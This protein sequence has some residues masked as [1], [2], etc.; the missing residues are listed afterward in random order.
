MKNARPTPTLD[1]ILGPNE[2][3]T[4]RGGGHKTKTLTAIEIRASWPRSILYF[5]VM[6]RSSHDD[7]HP[8]I[9]VAVAVHCAPSVPSEFFMDCSWVEARVEEQGRL[10][11]D[12]KK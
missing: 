12:K 10:V 3:A 2:K 5:Y 4:S 11:L 6:F 7:K 1:R 9:V 8:Y